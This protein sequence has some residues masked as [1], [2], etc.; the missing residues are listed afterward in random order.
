MSV[1]QCA[2]CDGI[3]DSDFVEIELIDGELVCMECYLE[4]K[5]EKDEKNN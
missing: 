3:Y 4:Y 5:E 2:K 1:F